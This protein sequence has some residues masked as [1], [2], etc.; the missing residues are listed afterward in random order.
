MVELLE[1]LEH[2]PVNDGGPGG[3]VECLQKCH[4]FLDVLLHFPDGVLRELVAG[5]GGQQGCQYVLGESHPH[6]LLG[7]LP[8]GH[9]E[10]VEFGFLAQETVEGLV[11]IDH[12]GWLLGLPGRFHVG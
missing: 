5:D 11:L 4:V 7:Q 3:R 10:E 9:L 8:A 1:T 12:V 6:L 2:L